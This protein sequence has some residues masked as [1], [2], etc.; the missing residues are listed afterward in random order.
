[1]TSTL[2]SDGHPGDSHLE[3]LVQRAKEGDQDAQWELILRRASDNA[4]AERERFEEPGIHPLHVVPKKPISHR[5]LPK[6]FRSMDQ[7]DPD[8]VELFRQLVAGRAKWPLFLHGP[9]GTG[10]TFAALCL[11]DHLPTAAYL[12]V[13]ELC[14]YVMTRHHIEVAAHW[15]ELGKK[16]LV[17]LDELGTRIKSGGDLEY[18]T[19]LKLLSLREREQNRAIICISNVSPESTIELYDR[20][21]YS[22]MCSGSVF[23]LAGP[24]RRGEGSES[25]PAKQ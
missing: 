2:N 6:A 8:L 11:C 17:V 4:A 19:V 5:L 23:A 25:C 18:N 7:V 12:T 1:M 9:V 3:G 15:N 13:E 22:R 20:R 10:K 24:D 14:D 16:D 21:I